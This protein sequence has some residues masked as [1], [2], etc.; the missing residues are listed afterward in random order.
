MKNETYLREQI[1][2]HPSA[3]PADLVKL[4]YQARYGAEH[5][6]TD[7]PAAREYFMRE[8]SSVPA[9]DADLFEEISPDYARVNFSAWKKKDLP[10]EWLFR[11][12]ALTASRP[13][14]TEQAAFSPIHHSE[15]YREKEHPAY[16]IVSLKMLR[17]LPVL[18]KLS[19]MP[20]FSSGLP[21]EKKNILIAVDGRAASGKT[22]LA[23]ELG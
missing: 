22:T 13:V 6:L 15:V 5:L 4:L 20:P 7:I 14:Q 17:L 12:F 1:K 23:D 8:F 9:D 11:M 18:K 21:E 16:R 2:K 10:P 3:R 19:E